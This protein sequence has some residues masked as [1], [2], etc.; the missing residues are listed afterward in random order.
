VVEE[1]KWSRPFF[2]HGGTILCNISAFKAHCSF[3]V[4]GRG[5]GQ[6][7]AKEDGVVQEGGMGS[8]GKI[9]SVKDLPADKKLLG[10]IRQ[11]AALID[12]GLGDNRMVV[13]R[14]VVKAPKP[15]VEDTGGVYG[16]AEA[17]PQGGGEGV[18]GVQ[19]KLPAGV[20]RVD[21][22]MPNGRRRG[23]GGLRR[24]WS[25]LR[26]GSSGT[27]S[28]RSVRSRYNSALKG[29]ND[30]EN[31]LNR[32]IMPDH[33]RSICE[34]LVETDLYILPGI[35]L[36]V[37]EALKV[38]S[39]RSTSP[40]RMAVLVLPPHAIF[41]VTDGQHRLKAVAEALLKKPE[42]GRDALP[43]TIVVEPDAD[44]IH[45]DFADCAQTRPI[46]PALLTLYNRSD[47]LSK[48]TVE[49]ANGVRYFDKRLEKV[50]NA[51]SKRSTN[52]YTLNHLRMSIASAM[53]GNS[54]AGGAALS[55]ATGGMLTSDAERR[56]WKTKLEWFYST[57]SEEIPE[58]RIVRDANLG[59]GTL[60][61][62]LVNFRASYFHFTG[63]GLA[64]MGA[65]A[66]RI[67]KF[68]DDQAEREEKV[69][70]LARHI[71]WR[72]LG[73]DGAPN[74]FWLGTIVSSDGKMVTS[75]YAAEAAV[76]GW[77]VVEADE[78][79]VVRRGRAW[80]L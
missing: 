32:P 22:R 80:R 36:N 33:V 41:Y 25:G 9:T 65:V 16:G 4:L 79:D 70:D 63:T 37:K 12:S 69:L 58:W 60:P 54:A 19:P 76:G 26:K 42:L 38:Y 1:M 28:I 47:E 53:T 29:N 49:V 8:L 10:Y 39:I 13:A 77:D 40:A 35:T 44:Q 27:G 11:A 66:Y 61:S 48:L 34:Y 3:R 30:P 50:G 18:C 45:Q 2:L 51:V 31:F 43:V 21:R 71:D 67:F 68:Y 5:D 73:D 6:G 24:R 75:R 72:R 20:C 64:I 46:P 56:E 52:F 78:V 23:I 14:R 62:D 7:A 55:H 74:P 59:L 17:R 57:L 15:P